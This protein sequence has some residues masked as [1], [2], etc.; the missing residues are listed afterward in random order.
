MFDKYM[1]VEE[2][3]RN[4]TS[5]G[6]VTGFELGARLPYY[7]GLG[8]S[9]VENIAVSVDGTAVPRENVRLS[10]RGRTWTLAEME[11]EYDEAWGMGEVGLVQVVQEGGLA[12]GSH[13]IELT[14]QLRVSYMPFPTIGKDTKTLTL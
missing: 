9:M 5:G 6:R 11:K 12:P 13:T 8:L 2:G 4:V 10:L 3:F 1:I 14:E 7:R